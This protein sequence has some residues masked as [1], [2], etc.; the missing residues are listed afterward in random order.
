[1]SSE[2]ARLSWLNLGI[3]D[4]LVCSRSLI[5]MIRLWIC[6]KDWQ[7]PSPSLLWQRKGNV[8][9]KRISRLFPSQSSN[10]THSGHNSA[11]RFAL[12]TRNV[13][14]ETQQQRMISCPYP[15][16]TGVG[17]DNTSVFVYCLTGRA[18]LDHHYVAL[19]RSGRYMRYSAREHDGGTA[20]RVWTYRHALSSNV[21]ASTLWDTGSA[22]C[23]CL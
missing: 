22:S 13:P 11:E 5:Y 14:R 9:L 7:D 23:I 10:P 2:I 15:W 17:I 8:P 1:M 3:I 12:F 6:C 20:L 16:V 18:G 19:T 4:L 21:P